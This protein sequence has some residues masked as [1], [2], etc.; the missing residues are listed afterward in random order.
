MRAWLSLAL[1]VAEMSRPGVNHIRHDVDGVVGYWRVPS[2]GWFGYRQQQCATHLSSSAVS[3][4]HSTRPHPGGCAAS[5][6]AMA[7]L[8]RGPMLRDWE[9]ALASVPPGAEA[10]HWLAMDTPPPKL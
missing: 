7:R 8:L 3:V 4:L 1:W 6:D 2:G 9:A 10:A 5:F